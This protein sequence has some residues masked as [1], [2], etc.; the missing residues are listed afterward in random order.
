MQTSH[1]TQ[2]TG[3][4]QPF[5]AAKPY[6]PEPLVSRRVS[7]SRAVAFD[8]EAIRTGRCRQTLAAAFR[9]IGHGMEPFRAFDRARDFYR[10]SGHAWT[11]GLSA[12]SR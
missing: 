12:S 9:S 8:G 5:P 6:R 11:T 3:T 2:T 4:A 7:M 1:Q 10:S